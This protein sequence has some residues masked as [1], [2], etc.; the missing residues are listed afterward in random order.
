MHRSGLK[1][2][3]ISSKGIAGALAMVSSRSALASAEFLALAFVAL[4]AIGSP[5]F[6]QSQAAPIPTNA[7]PKSYG[8]G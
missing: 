8:E 2:S 6:A 4:I 1:L 3:P 7:Q 5:S